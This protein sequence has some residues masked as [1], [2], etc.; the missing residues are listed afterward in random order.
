[1]IG[2]QDY[3]LTEMLL[4]H[5]FYV[6]YRDNI[7]L[8]DMTIEM[9]NTV[10]L[11]TLQ[12]KKTSRPPV[13]FMRQAGRILPDYLKLR[14][15]YSFKELMEV[16]ELCAEVTIMPLLELGVDA[17][18]LFSDILVIPEALGMKLEFTDKGPVFETPLKQN[19]AKADTLIERDESK[20]EYI[21]KN[22][23]VI[24]QKM[25]NQ[26]PLIGFCGSPLTTLC[27]MVQ[28]RSTNH[29]F[30][31]AIDFIYKY[32]EVAHSLVDTIT[33]LSILYAKEQIKAGVSSFQL[34]E[35]HAGLL[36]LPLYRSLILPAVKKIAKA[37]RA[38]GVP[39]IY[40]SKGLSTGLGDFADNSVDF[41]SVD[42]Q[43]PLTDVLKLTNNEMGVQGN[44]DPRIVNAP[45]DVIKKH[46]DEH[47]LD[48]GRSHDK[49]I[50][51]LGHGF[52]PDLSWQ[53]AKCVVDWIKSADWSST[54][55]A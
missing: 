35:T 52:T 26:M 42:W 54:G 11:D 40:F 32:P 38:E 28:G 5:D 1:M 9:D 6:N 41:L 30:P 31:D 15:K 25:P 8:I 4:L 21:Y 36:P 14:E 37:V 45:H 19:L 50:F 3:S 27:Y 55:N 12:G 29:T 49:W 2:K 44:L 23:E 43:I 20:L 24:L 16:P 22:I 33:D 53:G 34:F 51:N 17:A 13:W 46:L 18:I 39:F 47:Y 10:F 48:F 7:S